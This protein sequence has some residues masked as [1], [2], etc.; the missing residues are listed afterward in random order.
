M[1]IS[2]LL[3][4]LLLI[5][6]LLSAQPKKSF[7]IN[8][9]VENLKTPGKLILTVRDVNQWTE[10]IAESGT[11]KFTLTGSVRE[12]SFAYLVM[13][14][15][16]ELDKGP[17]MANVSQL[18]VD[19]TVIKIQAKDSLNTASIEGGAIQKDLELLNTTLA[20]W[21]KSYY[22]TSQLIRKQDVLGKIHRRAS[23]FVRKH[24]RDTE[25]FDGRV[26]RDRR[27]RS[28]ATVRQAFA[29][30]EEYL[31]RK[32]ADER[33]PDRTPDIHRRHCPGVC[34]KRYSG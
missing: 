8:V 17:R 19:N 11:G 16:N 14:Y 32:G 26:L 18:F 30:S 13:K 7:H 23:V 27:H 5:S 10:Y 20:D 1:K 22:E 25:L 28:G 33:H 12:P 29:G 4:F 2:P 6:S 3:L 15:G 24:L 31:I 21:K 9:T 34:S